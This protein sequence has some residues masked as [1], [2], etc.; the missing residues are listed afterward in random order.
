MKFSLLEM[1]DFVIFYQQTAKQI[2][3]HEVHHINNYTAGS[4]SYL[5]TCWTLS[6]IYLPVEQNRWKIESVFCV[7]GDPLHLHGPPHLQECRKQGIRVT[8]LQ[9]KNA[10][11]IKQFTV[12]NA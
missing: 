6:H 8:G 9:V 12:M 10:K 11:T 5:F 3:I 4:E 7:V 2:I 1:T